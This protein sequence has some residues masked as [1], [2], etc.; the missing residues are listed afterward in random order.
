MSN[1]IGLSQYHEDN[2][3][4]LAAYLLEGDLK[5]D[6][7]MWKFS[8]HGKDEDE[9]TDCGTVGCAAGHGP[10]AGIQKLETEDWWQYTYR[11]FG[12]KATKDE[13]WDWVFHGGWSHVDPSPQ[14]AAKR[15]LNLLENGLPPTAEAQRCGA[16]PI[17]YL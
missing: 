17:S 1:V 14:G 13:R 12:F 11:V 8:S 15:I 3:R 7:N 5:A 10:Y 6:F 16:E 9:E 4:K 2:L